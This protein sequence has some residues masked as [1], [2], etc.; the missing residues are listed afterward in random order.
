MP[1]PGRF[2]EEI[3]QA[4]SGTPFD[5]S[6]PGTVDHPRCATSGRRWQRGALGARPRSIVPASFAVS[7]RASVERQ[8]VI[9][10]A[11]AVMSSFCEADPLNAITASKIASVI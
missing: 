10:T 8:A 7:E 9:F 5:E 4:V 3:R 11:T 1:K 2:T 6:V